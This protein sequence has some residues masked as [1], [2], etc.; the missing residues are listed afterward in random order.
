VVV[1]AVQTDKTKESRVAVTKEIKGLAGEGKLAGE[2]FERQPKFVQHIRSMLKPGDALLLFPIM[3]CSESLEGRQVECCRDRWLPVPTTTTNV[4]T[5]LRLLTGI[6][7][8]LRLTEGG[9]DV[10]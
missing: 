2:E 1:A 8:I 7:G 3:F 4:N 10:H 6:A 9:I 5:I